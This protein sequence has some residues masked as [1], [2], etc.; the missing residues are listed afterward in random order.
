MMRIVRKKKRDDN[1]RPRVNLLSCSNACTFLISWKAVWANTEDDQRVWFSYTEANVIKRVWKIK[2]KQCNEFLSSAERIH[3]FIH[4]QLLGP[5]AHGVALGTDAATRLEQLE[6]YVKGLQ[7]L[8]FMDERGDPIDVRA[9]EERVQQ[10]E[11]LP[12]AKRR[13]HNTD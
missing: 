10:L 8:D 13:K 7:T 6:G 9:L 3:D 2:G 4:M 1:Q 12:N 5:C 11:Q